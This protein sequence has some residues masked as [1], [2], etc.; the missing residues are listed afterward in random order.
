ML[1]MFLIQYDP[2]V[3][4]APTDK[5]SLLPEHEALEADLRQTGV[6][7]SGGALMPVEMAR[8]LRVKAGAV[9]GSDGPF[10]ETKEAIGGYYII[11][12]RDA[13][14]AAAYAARIPVPSNAWVEAR[15]LVLFHPDVGRIAKLATASA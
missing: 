13:A 6:Y 14:E 10:A 9:I 8:P 3:P 11:D 12:C 2:A 5:P 7:V 15:Q 4:L 1:Y